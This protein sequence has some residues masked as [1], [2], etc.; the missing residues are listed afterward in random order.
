[1]RLIK[2]CKI[3]NQPFAGLLQDGVFKNFPKFTEI[4]LCRSLFLNKVASEL[5][6]N[7]MSNFFIEHLMTTSCE[8]EGLSFVQNL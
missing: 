5:W 2:L 4:H 1:M 3:Q 7:F 6:Q 8:N